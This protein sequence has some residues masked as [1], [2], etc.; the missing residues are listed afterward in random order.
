MTKFPHNKLYQDK[1]HTSTHTV[2]DIY[3]CIYGCITFW[4]LLPCRPSS[5]PTTNFNWFINPMKTFIFLIWRKF[6]KFIIALIIL[7]VLTVFLVL[8]I[9][10]LPQQISSLIINGWRNLSATDA[11]I[12]QRVINR[13]PAPVFVGLGLWKGEFPVIQKNEHHH[14]LHYNIC[15]P[16]SFIICT[17]EHCLVW[18]TV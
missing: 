18:F 16:F 10:T 7:G 4:Q 17:Y 15:S 5:R 9:Y 2:S 1:K 6:K 13:T 14:R 8:I 11:D 3:S 12:Q